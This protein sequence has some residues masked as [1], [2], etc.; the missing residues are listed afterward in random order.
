MINSDLVTR[1][2]L[3]PLERLTT[4]SY[5]HLACNHK[6]IQRILQLK[7]WQVRKRPWIPTSRPEPA[8]LPRA[9]EQN[10]LIE[11]SFRPFKEECI[12]Q[13]RFESLGQ[14]RA[15]ISRWIRHYNE[16]RPQQ[17]LG[18]MAPGSYLAL[19]A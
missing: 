15:V 14:A 18:Y 9:P 2:E 8:A 3:A 1:V 7:R 6:S 17:S 16:E 4:H 12:W 11:R 19:T 10:G 5:R 13:H